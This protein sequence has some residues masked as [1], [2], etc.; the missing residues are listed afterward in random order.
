MHIKI[1]K[2]ETTKENIA[3]LINLMNE[4]WLNL[5][6]ASKLLRLKTE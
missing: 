3:R 1:P 2:V 6:L 5:P 4:R